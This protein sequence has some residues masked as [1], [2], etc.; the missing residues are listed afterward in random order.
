MRRTVLDAIVAVLAVG[1]GVLAM[2]RGQ[3]WLGGCFIAIGVL[4]AL[5][6]LPRLITPKPP[7]KIRL[8]LEDSPEGDSRT[9]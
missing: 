9:R 7:E 8:N 6:K 5:L 1:L 2:V 3:Y 4:R